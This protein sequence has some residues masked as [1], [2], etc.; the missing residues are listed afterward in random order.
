MFLVLVNLPM[1]V[2]GLIRIDMIYQ[3]VMVRVRPLLYIM[4]TFM[5]QV[6]MIMDLA[7]GKTGKELI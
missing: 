7:T 6:G 3:V 5:L 2:I 1:P 4:E